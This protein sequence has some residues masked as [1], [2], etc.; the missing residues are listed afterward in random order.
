MCSRKP[1]P[2]LDP[3][4][5]SDSQKKPEMIAEL[6]CDEESNCM[7]DEDANVLV[8]RIRNAKGTTTLQVRQGITESD[9][10]EEFSR[11]KRIGK[12]RVHPYA[13]ASMSQTLTED[14]EYAFFI[15]KPCRGGLEIYVKEGDTWHE[16]TISEDT[17]VCDILY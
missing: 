11:M 4:D 15:S 16:I 10:L 2:A 9:L 12:E 17:T 1:L 3:I 13:K 5:L 7:V 8:V 6:N 14:S